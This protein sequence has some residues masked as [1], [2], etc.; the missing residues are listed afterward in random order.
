MRTLF[1]TMRQLWRLHP[2]IFT[3]GGI[4]RRKRGKSIYP[5]DNHMQHCGERVLRILGQRPVEKFHTNRSLLLARR[6][7][8]ARYGAVTLTRQQ[9]AWGCEHSFLSHQNFTWSGLSVPSAFRAI[10]CWPCTWQK[11]IADRVSSP[12]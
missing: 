10:K 5:Y 3:C 9:K 6:S 12:V 7:A 8:S 1:H 2:S 4:K 11:M